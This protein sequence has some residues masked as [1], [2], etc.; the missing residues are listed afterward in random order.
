MDPSSDRND[1][2]LEIEVTRAQAWDIYTLLAA[3]AEMIET[4]EHAGH[5]DLG[6]SRYRK[7]AWEIQW[8][9]DGKP[10]VEVMS[11]RAS[12]REDHHGR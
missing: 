12:S 1:A 4:A 2:I 3:K 11:G 9:L 6:S 8:A 10:P 5:C 7:A